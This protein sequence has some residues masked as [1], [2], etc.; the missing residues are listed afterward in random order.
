ML[1]AWQREKPGALFS[2]ADGQRQRSPAEFTVPL[3]LR[4]AR[5]R[6]ITTTERA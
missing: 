6:P 3:L 4:T 1:A 5:H 2:G